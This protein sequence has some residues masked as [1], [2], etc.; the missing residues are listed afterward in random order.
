MTSREKYYKSKL[1]HHRE[2][3][4]HHMSMASQGIHEDYHTKQ[5]DMHRQKLA[6]LE[7][8]GKKRKP[9]KKDIGPM[10]GAPQNGP[11]SGLIGNF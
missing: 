4:E 3:I 2:A 10:S 7:Q 9:E 8:K 5:A 1:T 6:E 11:A